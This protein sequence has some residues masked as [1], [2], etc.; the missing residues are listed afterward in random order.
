MDDEEEVIFESEDDPFAET[1][2]GSDFLSNEIRWGWLNGAEDEWIGEPYL[3]QRMVEHACF[4]SFEIDR[5]IGKF[6]HDP[7]IIER[8]R[9]FRVLFAG[10]I[11]GAIVIVLLSLM[12]PRAV[13]LPVESGVRKPQLPL[14]SDA[15][16]ESQRA[17]AA[18]QILPPTGVLIPVAG[19][20]PNDL[21][22]NYLQMRGGG[23]RTHGAIDIMAPRGTPVVAA[24]DGTIRKLFTSAGGG[25]TI[26]QFDVR[27]ELVYYYAHLDR[28]ELTMH[29]GLFVKQGTVIG[30][31]GTTGNAAPDA[32]HLHFAIEMLPP[33]KEWWKGTPMNPYPILT[34]GLS[35]FGGRQ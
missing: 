34:S 17:V 2:E 25:L 22:D 27:E 32:P 14:S 6:R 28:Y 10:W 3:F 20:G 4:E 11:I 26:Y 8:M 29:E 1:A 13:A 35:A 30:Y 31:V 9:T 15:T 12:Q 16:N 33:T 18:L 21:H 23:T 5:H 19:M 7:F 24:V